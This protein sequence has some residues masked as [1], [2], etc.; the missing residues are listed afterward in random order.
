MGNR[1]FTATTTPQRWSASLCDAVLTH[2]RAIHV[3]CDDSVVRLVGDVLLPIRRARGFAP[4]PVP[5]GHGRRAVLAVGGELKNTFCL[6]S[7]EHAWMSQHIGDMENLDTLDAF[8][9]SVAQFAALYAVRPDVVAVDAHPGYATA[10][11][12][13]PVDTPIVSSRSSTITP[14]SQR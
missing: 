2:D 6:A 4:L 7:R 5:V 13:R 8:E 14:T 3:P 12:A 11:W 1:S 10:A 9:R